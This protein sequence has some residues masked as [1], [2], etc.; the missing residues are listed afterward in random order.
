MNNK[1]IR[2]I[3]AGGRDF[4]DYQSLK[5]KLDYFLKDRRC[6]DIEIISGTARGADQL[7]ERYAKERGL[8]LVRCPAEWDKFGKRAGY[9]RNSHMATLATHCVC[10]WDGS[11][12][13]TRHMIN[14]AKSAGLD[15]RIID[16]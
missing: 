6:D 16:Y 7:G 3:V 4:A 14:L 8:E 10:A 12:S 13:G 9:L 15:L 1:P 11:S 2:L 5:T